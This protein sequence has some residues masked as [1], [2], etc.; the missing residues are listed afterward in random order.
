MCVHVINY[1]RSPPMCSQSVHPSSMQTPWKR[2]NFEAC[3]KWYIYIYWEKKFCFRSKMSKN[4]PV[5]KIIAMK[6]LIWVCLKQTRPELLLWMQ[7]KRQTAF[8]NA[9]KI[10]YFNR[11][12]NKRL[13]VEF[14]PR[15]SRWPSF[16]TEM[17]NI[18]GTPKL[19]KPF[20]T[21][22]TTEG[23]YTMQWRTWIVLLPH[24]SSVY[25]ISLVYST[26]RIWI[27]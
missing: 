22:K 7:K 19:N 5:P 16:C 21:F 8:M 9:I 23:K 12:I 3:L 14:S 6:Q 26:L 25:S 10:N 15:T 4:I 27:C 11:Y 24:P 20:V 17:N 18:R 2:A 1:H 13:K